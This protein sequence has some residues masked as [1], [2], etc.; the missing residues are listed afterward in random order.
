VLQTLRK[1]DTL[2]QAA[3]GLHNAITERDTAAAERDTAAA[4]RD[5]VAAERD[6]ATAERDTAT[7]ERDT[8]TAERDV[9]TAERDA[10]LGLLR[11]AAEGDVAMQGGDH[12]RRKVHGYRT[13]SRQSV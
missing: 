7:A 1:D 2:T 12:K 11:R 10:A 9:A 5:T 3:I 8:A 6:T 13:R 4:E